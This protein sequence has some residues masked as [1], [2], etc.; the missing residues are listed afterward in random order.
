MADRPVAIITGASRGIG[1]GI[2][3]ELASL[4]YDLVLNYYDFKDGQ[5]DDATAEQ[6][7][8]EIKATGT[9]CQ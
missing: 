9:D 4:G 7:Q 2:A 8:K 3:K 6:T 1:K 5:P